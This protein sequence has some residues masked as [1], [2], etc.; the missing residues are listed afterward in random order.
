MK[1]NQ[2]AG[3]HFLHVKDTDTPKRISTTWL[4]PQVGKVPEQ[5]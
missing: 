2:K 4:F 3:V 5:F 1:I